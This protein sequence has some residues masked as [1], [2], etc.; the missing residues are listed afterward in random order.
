MD[1][2]RWARWSGL[3]E[4]YGFAIAKVKEE[5]SKLSVNFVAGILY[6]SCSQ[7]RDAYACYVNAT[8]GLETNGQVNEISLKISITQSCIPSLNSNLAQRIKFLQGQL[9]TASMPSIT[10]KWVWFIQFFWDCTSKMTVRWT[11]TSF[12]ETNLIIDP[13]FLRELWILWDRRTW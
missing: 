9:C 4:I 3:S 13:P 6:E 8:R 10:S 11:S 5:N 7:P 2:F 12:S 1:Q